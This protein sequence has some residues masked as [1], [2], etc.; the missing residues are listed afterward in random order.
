MRIE[1]ACM[2]REIFIELQQYLLR[3]GKSKQAHNYPRAYLE[4]FESVNVDG[5]SDV[6][7]DD[8]KIKVLDQDLTKEEL[9]GLMKFLYEPKEKRE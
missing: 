2:K 9:D 3:L 1:K 8:I 5:V 4:S 7:Y 6:Y